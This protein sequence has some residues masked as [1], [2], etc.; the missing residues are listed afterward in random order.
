ML[1]LD[2]QSNFLITV[3]VNGLIN[4]D[5]L[6]NNTSTILNIS[7]SDLS[8]S[9]AKKLFDPNVCSYL[10]VAQAFLPLPLKSKGMIVN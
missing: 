2:M 6:V 4:L 5:I 1:Q 3:Y 10:A 8:I 9:E 7:M